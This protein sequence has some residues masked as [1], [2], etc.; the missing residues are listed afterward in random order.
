MKGERGK[1]IYWCMPTVLPLIFS[2]IFSL[3]FSVFFLIFFLLLFT[4]FFLFTPRM[5]CFSV[6]FSGHGKGPFIVPIV[7]NVLLFCPLTAFV[8]SGRTCRPTS[9]VTFTLARQRQVCF[10]P[11]STVT[12]FS[13]HGINALS[14]YSQGMH[15]TVPPQTCF[16][17]VVCHPSSTY[18]SKGLEQEP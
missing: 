7:T 6:P 5:L 18:L 15:L 2:L 1:P 11:Q 4:L 13:C 10:V 14:F 12:L 16:F 17:W 9:R 3:F 8:W